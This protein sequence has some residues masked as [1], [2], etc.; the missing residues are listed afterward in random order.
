MLHAMAQGSS[1]RVVIVVE[2]RLKR[3]LYGELARR[4]TTLKA[5]FIE[6]ATRFLET[7]QQ[8]SL[9]VS[10]DMHRLKPRMPSGTRS[11][12]EEGSE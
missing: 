1:G 8:P 12:A 3:E 9:F 2:P 6:Q 7:S 5:W 11:S 4:G 10:E